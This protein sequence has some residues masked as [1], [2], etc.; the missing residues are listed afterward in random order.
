VYATVLERWWDL[1]SERALG[2]RF[3]L[4]PILHGSRGAVDG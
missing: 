2:R 3:E 1:D 4:L